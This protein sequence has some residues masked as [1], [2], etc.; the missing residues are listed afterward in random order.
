M[1]KRRITRVSKQE[2]GV[3][4][5]K[6]KKVRGECMR[7]EVGKSREKIGYSGLDTEMEIVREIN[8][9]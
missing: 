5:K 2:K 1:E 6:S 4:E 8:N 9:L 3:E 7:K